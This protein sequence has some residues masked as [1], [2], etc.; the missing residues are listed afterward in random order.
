MPHAQPE[1]DAGR[2]VRVLPEA[3]GRTAAR[4]PA[5]H[6]VSVRQASSVSVL[7]RCVESEYARFAEAFLPTCSSS[8]SDAPRSASVTRNTAES[9]APSRAGLR[10]GNARKAQTT[11]NATSAR[12]RP[13]IARCVNS[14]MVAAPGEC[15]VTAPLQSGQRLPHPAPDPVAR[16]YAPQSTTVRL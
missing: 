13:L 6:A 5:H 11:S 1:K 14:M 12:S 15:G 3:L 8:T 9:A 2:R 7:I 16:T 10:G 4:P